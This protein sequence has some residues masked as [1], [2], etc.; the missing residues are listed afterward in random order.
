ME[1]ILRLV[2]AVCTLVCCSQLAAQHD[3]SFWNRHGFGE[4]LQFPWYTYFGE[5][6]TADARYNYDQKKTLG[7]YFGKKFG[8]RKFSVVAEAG[9]LAGQYKGIGP[10]LHILASVRGWEVFTQSQ[11]SKGLKGCTDFQYHWVD[12]LRPIGKHWAV[13]AD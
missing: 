12:V 5:K 10:E 4:E 9:M 1:D 6:F 7:L 11:Y 8:S 13:G 2:S 3:V